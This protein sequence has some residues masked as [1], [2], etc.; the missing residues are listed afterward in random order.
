[1]SSAR[2]ITSAVNPPRAVYLDYPLGHTAGKVDDA[3]NQMDIMRDT[4]TAFESIKQP[5]TI[6][7]LSYEWCADDA[8]KDK[9]MRPQPRVGESDSSDNAH[10]DDRIARVATPQYQ[11][12]DDETQADSQCPSC[13][14]LED[15]K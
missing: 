14:F 5:G 1:M 4:L 3:V 7:D 13:I 11:T 2:S 10:N 15:V 9:V 8:W 12:V 6:V